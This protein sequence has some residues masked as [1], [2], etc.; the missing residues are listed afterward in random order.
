MAQPKYSLQTCLQARVE[1]ADRA[2]R[3][4]GSA[5]QAA[6]AAELSRTRA[7][8][9][10]EEHERAAS[11]VRDSERAA[12]DRGALTVFDL[13]LAAVWS[14][15][16]AETG[17]RLDAATEGARA[18][19]GRAREVERIG[20]LELAWIA[21]GRGDPHLDPVARMERHPADRRL[22]RAAATGHLHR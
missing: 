20:V 22:P 5:L 7:E 1:G 2:A 3:D 8:Q 16:A 15:G 10:R 19:E 11:A 13:A 14:I 21:V 4:L 9:Q 17:R 18:A 12:L 6:R